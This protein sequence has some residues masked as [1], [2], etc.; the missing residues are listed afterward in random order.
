MKVVIISKSARTGGAA[1]AATRLL[2]ALRKNSVDAHML[3]QATDAEDIPGV[4]TTT[5]SGTRK[6]INTLRF[7]Y[8]RMVFVLFE[9]SKTVRFMFSLANT[10]EDLSRQKM[11]KEADIIHL[12]WINAGFISLRGLY[13][14]LDLDKPVVWTF[15]DMWAFTGGCHYAG[16]CIN[17][18]SNCGYC[19]YLRR[20][21]RKDL[22]NRVL[23][24]KQKIFEGREFT[25]I[26]PSK[27]L[28]E[29]VTSSSLLGSFNIHVIPNPIDHNLFC[30][31]N[32]EQIQL[33]LG[34]D[35]AKK[36]ILFG[37]QNIRN[38]LKGFQYFL[39]AMQI[40]YEE[41]EDRGST[42]VILFGKST[43]EALNSIPFKTHDYSVI[44][45][46]ERLIELYNSA[47]LMVVPSIQDNLPT[48]I[49]ECFS[50]GTPVVGFRT[51]GI[52][53]MIEHKVNGYLAENRSDRDL[54]NGIR[55]VLENNDYDTIARNARQ[56]VLDTYTEEIIS[57]KCMDL[58]KQLLN[59]T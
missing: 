24:K 59:G 37:A 8:E 46:E 17:Y 54:A 50:C 6:L 44:R 45:S 29:C 3:V 43:K 41:L 30:P 36:Y 33:R 35:P 13:R 16:D 14:L 49:M 53:E 15:H 18:Q 57:A 56:K 52:P 31:G 32:I 25:I 9:E 34:L 19:Y 28:K 23:R 38:I 20:Q 22:S 58:Y 51:G 55:W 2:R 1:I 11:V 7:I 39:R 12:H 48:T 5:R 40:L 4:F 26:T 10:G 21:H 47:R 27:W 42:E